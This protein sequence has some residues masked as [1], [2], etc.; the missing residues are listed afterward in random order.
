M[1]IHVNRLARRHLKRIYF[2]IVLSCT[3]LFQTHQDSFLSPGPK[4]EER[5]Y[6]NTLNEHIVCSICSGY[7]VNASMVP[8]CQ[9]TFCKSCLVKFLYHHN[10]CPEC[11]IVI[12]PTDPLAYIRTDRIL[13]D[14]I[15]KLVPN[16]EE[17]ER[18]RERAFYLSLSKKETA[19]TSPKAEHMSLATVSPDEKEIDLRDTSKDDTPQQMVASQSSPHILV[20]DDLISTTSPIGEMEMNNN[21]INNNKNAV[22]HHCTSAQH[23]DNEKV[24]SQSRHWQTCR[25]DNLMTTSNLDSADRK[26]VAYVR[27]SPRRAVKRPP[28]PPQ[29]H[30]NDGGS[31]GKRRQRI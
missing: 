24:S 31:P 2:F 20:C 12:H 10:T 30:T 27:V 4:M 22:F 28:F 11:H 5:I 7:I 3:L 1:N 25:Y 9:H 13:N 19:E 26:A 18:Q 16:L 14:I 21:K 15:C 29:G 6:L 17:N 23:V 8:E